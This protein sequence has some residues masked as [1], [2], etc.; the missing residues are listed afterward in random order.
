MQSCKAIVH[1]NWQYM[2]QSRFKLVTAGERNFLQNIEIS[3]TSIYSVWGWVLRPSCHPN[4][5]YWLLTKQCFYLFIS[6]LLEHANGKV[7]CKYIH[8]YIDLS[9]H[10]RYCLSFSGIQD[11]KEHRRNLESQ[12]TEQ[13]PDKE[14]I[15]YVNTWELIFQDFLNLIKVIVIHSFNFYPAS[16]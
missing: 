16:L 13:Y 15:L 4:F 1:L 7:A 11:E 10:P 8:A 6:C 5:L 9:G 12:V 14:N 2:D 3:N